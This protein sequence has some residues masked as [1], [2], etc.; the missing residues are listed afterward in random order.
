MC[1]TLR[2]RWTLIP[3]TAPQP[4]IACSGCGGPRPFRCSGKI[5]LNANG[6]R[7]DAWL[8]YRCLACDKTWNRPVFER[9]NVRAIDPRLLEAL[10]SNDPDWIRTL[11]FDVEALRRKAHRVDEFPD[12]AIDKEILEEPPGWTSLRI[13]LAA[14]SPVDLRL[15]RLM[16]AELK[17]PRARLKALH[18]SGS[19]RTEPEGMLRRRIRSGTLVVV[20]LSAEDRRMPCW[21]EWAT[22]DPT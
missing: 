15:D 12:C 18:E 7:L 8:I 9:Q 21:R 20:D 6:R 3:Q 14:P 19:L 5:R 2:V 4:W 1:K 11:A 17:I 13:E 22:V 10:Q 16:A